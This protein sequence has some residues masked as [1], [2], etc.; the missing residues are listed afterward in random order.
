MTDPEYTFIKGQ[1]WV[2]TYEEFEYTEVIGRYRVTLVK[3][4]PE[5][6]EFHFYEAPTFFKD[7]HQEMD[8]LKQ[9]HRGR[10]DGASTV[11]ELSFP[12]FGNLPMDHYDDKGIFITMLLE[13]L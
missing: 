3:R 10:F 4:K 9:W 7:L 2:P 1:G 5:I 8:A 12:K 13:P 6:G 11:L